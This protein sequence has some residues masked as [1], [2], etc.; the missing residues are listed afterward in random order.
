MASK[1]RPSEYLRKMRRIYIL[2]NQSER[3][4]KV[5]AGI[6]EYW[7]HTHISIEEGV[8][9]IQLAQANPFSMDIQICCGVLCG[10]G[11]NRV[12]TFIK[13]TSCID[14]GISASY[15]AIQR[16]HAYMDYHLNLYALGLHG[17]EIMM[18]SDHIQPKSK[19]GSDGMFNRQPMCKPCNGR[20][21]DQW[22]PQK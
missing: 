5:A 7:T 6:T 9:R 11:S 22:H 8:R 3:S 16:R 4:N 19:G 21:A 12:K 14:C 18:T 15:F 20:K 10:F 1:K 13:G 2:R 17:N